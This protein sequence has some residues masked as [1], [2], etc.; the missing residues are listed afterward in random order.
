MGGKVLTVCKIKLERPCVYVAAM[1][2]KQD[3][4][5]LKEGRRRKEKEKAS[6]NLPRSCEDV[7]V[8]EGRRAKDA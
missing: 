5:M 8:T 6:H 7:D 3:V 4:S 2:V 1:A